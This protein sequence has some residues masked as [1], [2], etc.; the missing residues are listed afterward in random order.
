MGPVFLASNRKRPKAYVEL[1]AELI[2]GK[3]N[4]VSKPLLKSMI[5]DFS[6]RVELRLNVW[7]VIFA[8]YLPAR[9]RS[10]RTN[11][12]LQVARASTEKLN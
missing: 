5:W 1:H 9:C 2:D 7:L 6:R 10:K 11:K 4:S 3:L 8:C 12:L